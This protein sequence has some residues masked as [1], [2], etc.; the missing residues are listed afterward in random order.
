MNYLIGHHKK[1]KG[2]NN[3]IFKPYQMIVVQ[4]D[5]DLNEMFEHQQFDAAR[6]VQYDADIL[7]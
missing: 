5:T 7:C 4:P 2:K 1:L 3:M 6:D